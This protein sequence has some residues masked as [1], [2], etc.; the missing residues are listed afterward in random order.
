MD[1]DAK[2]P[3]DSLEIIHSEPENDSTEALYDYQRMLANKFCSKLLAMGKSLSNLRKSQFKHI[4][5]T[6]R[7]IP[8]KRKKSFKYFELSFVLINLC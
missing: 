8:S 6:D 7:I 3:P 2:Y 4:D 1:E 5:D